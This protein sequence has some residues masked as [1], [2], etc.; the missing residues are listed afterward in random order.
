MFALETKFNI[1]FSVK[2]SIRLENDKIYIWIVQEWDH[3]LYV[4]L[5]SKMIGSIRPIELQTLFRK[6]NR[7]IDLYE[8]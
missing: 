6:R 8:Y 7:E 4:G 1:G 2:V 5:R 3:Q